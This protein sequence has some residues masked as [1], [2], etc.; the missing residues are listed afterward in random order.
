MKP[1]ISVIF[2]T[3]LIGAGQGLFLAL[4]VG[5]I[6]SLLGIVE[7]NPEQ[8]LWVGIVLVIALMALGLFASFFHL[9]RPMRAWRAIYKWRTSWLSREVIV[10]LL[11]IVAVLAWGV[12]IVSNAVI[13]KSETVFLELVIG[14]VAVVLA[15]LLYLCTAMIYVAVKCIQEW[16]TPFTVFNYFFS[17]L[18]SGF[19][20]TTALASYFQ[21]GMTSVYTSYSLTFVLL[22]FV[23]RML[24]TYRNSQIKQKHKIQV[25]PV[26]ENL[27]VRR[28]DRGNQKVTS[29]LLYQ[30]NSRLVAWIERIFPVL[31]F[32]LP[33]LIFFGYQNN[34]MMLVI[35]C[36]IQ[37]I[38]LITERWL[39]FVQTSHP[40]NAY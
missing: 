21:S 10:L 37:Y 7:R 5:E 30:H 24:S 35:A 27:N 8:M 34:T 20:L 22:A 31:A 32:V 11:F 17:G 39:F 19:F 26:L 28:V 3:T 14:M 4:Y 38:G 23:S 40:Q 33:G 1:P 12:F 18:A 15:L 13:F 36:V 9:G 2:L 16:H 6:Y 29:Q 25:I